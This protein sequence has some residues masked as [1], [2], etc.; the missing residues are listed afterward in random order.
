MQSPAPAPGLRL[1]LS[2]LSPQIGLQL[3]RETPGQQAATHNAFASTMSTAPVPSINGA[4]PRMVSEPQKPSIAIEPEGVT[5][6]QYPLPTEPLQIRQLQDH[7]GPHVP[8]QLRSAY[9]P[10]HALAPS[11]TVHP[12]RPGPD[13]D[14]T[15]GENPS[16]TPSKAPQSES[17]AGQTGTGGTREITSPRT[18]GT[19]GRSETP[20]WPHGRAA[21]LPPINQKQAALPAPPPS[22]APEGPVEPVNDD[23]AVPPFAPTPSRPSTT[24]GAPALAPTNTSAPVAFTPSAPPPA[25]GTGPDAD[26]QA[27]SSALPDLS[28]AAPPPAHDIAPSDERPSPVPAGAVARQIVRTLEHAG[29]DPQ[30]LVE[31]AL[32]PPELGR[33]RMSLAE[34]NGTLTL[35]I[36]VDRPETAELMRRHIAL[37]SEE[38]A[39]AGLDAPSVNIS[40][41]GAEGRQDPR[42]ALASPA[43]APDAVEPAHGLV[44]PA[45]RGGLD[46]RL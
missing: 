23:N 10:V 33:V 40:Q 15:D 42:T 28:L 43:P 37:L 1:A 22:A 24:T 38:F 30:G 35:A 39:R 16:L 44:R 26:L 14:P 46:L 32:D 25:P 31:L 17:A 27:G 13:A 8:E 18:A 21:P 19:G 20:L 3:I 7:M 29:R 11:M 9:A 12:L 6:R 41:G 34:V 5:I 36:A 45:A 4:A 2:S